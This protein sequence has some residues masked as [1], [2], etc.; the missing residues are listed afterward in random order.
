MH[1]LW[2]KIVD[3]QLAHEDPFLLIRIVDLTSTVEGMTQ[4]GLRKSLGINQPRLSKLQ[5][6]LVSRKWIVARKAPTDGRV[7]LVTATDHGMKIIS[8]LR[9]ELSAALPEPV[10]TTPERRRGAIKVPPGQRSLL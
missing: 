10:Q 4:S 6:K 8:R 1:S 5:K 3:A 9:L 7:V 2:K